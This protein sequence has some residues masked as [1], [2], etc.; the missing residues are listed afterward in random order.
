MD[1]QQSTGRQVACLEE[2]A[3][4]MGYIDKEQLHE[5]GESMKKTAY[6]Q[7]ILGL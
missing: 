6:G 1:I 4:N 2:I 7:Y 3:Y 5:V